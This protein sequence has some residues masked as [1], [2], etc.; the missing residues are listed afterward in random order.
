[1]LLNIEHDSFYTYSSPVFLEPHHFYFSPVAR[2]YYRIVDF[3]ITVDPSPVGL[4]QR[5]DAEGN[6]FHQCWFAEK[7]EHLKVSMK[8]ELETMVYNPFGFLIEESEGKKEVLAP[9]LKCQQLSEEFKRW[10]KSFEEHSKDGIITLLG[11]ICNQIHQEWTHEIRYEESLLDPNECF[12]TKKGS[13]RDLSWMLINGFR[14]LGI[15]SK[16][17]SGYSFNPELEEGHEL[18]AWVE[19]W[20]LGAGWVGLDPS[21]GLFT[22]EYYV[23]VAT[24]Y[25]PANTLPVQGNFRGDA[26][27]KL[28][29][30]VVITKAE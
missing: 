4:S 21:S 1:M 6:T 14:H 18:H 19:A 30:S 10:L 8:M 26:S 2:D 11:N 5:N 23:P 25:L 22:N 12:K 24:S 20:V 9:Y 17:V 3:S 13:C 27:S 7:L 29:T 15:A 16:F 28:E